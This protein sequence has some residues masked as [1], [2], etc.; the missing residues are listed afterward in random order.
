MKY[1]PWR[2]VQTIQKIT[3]LWP[4]RK[5]VK[6]LDMFPC[7]LCI[8]ENV[9]KQGVT[10]AKG[11]LAM[12]QKS[13]ADIIIHWKTKIDYKQLNNFFFNNQVGGA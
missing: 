6:L 2:E 1:C 10:G 7:R 12:G 11:V 4:S 9:I 3:V 13:F 5:N 8:F